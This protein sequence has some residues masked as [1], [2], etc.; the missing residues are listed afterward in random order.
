MAI[1][2][3]NTASSL[4]AILQ[5]IPGLT[6]AINGQ[7]STATTNATTSTQNNSGSTTTNSGI[8][9]DGLNALLSQLLS[10][11][12]GLA[13]VAGGQ[14][15]AG[16]YNS[17]VQQQA[18]NQL[19]VE[20]AGE[21]QA[22]GPTSTTVQNTGGTTSNTSGATTTVKAPSL[23]LGTTLLEAAG[24]IG[25]NKVLS[26]G[27]SALSNSTLGQSLANALG[28]G[29]GSSTAASSAAA[30]GAFN[31]GA[32]SAGVP[33]VGG[34]IGVSGVGVNTAGFTA[35]TAASLGSTGGLGG[36]SAGVSTGA[37]GVDASTA[38]VS[39]S[40]AGGADASGLIDAGTASSLG[41]GAGGAAAGLG[42]G[43]GAA[44]T[45]TAIAG[46][47]DAGLAAGGATL[48]GIGGAI[49]G[50]V[51]ASTAGIAAA[52]GVGDAAGAVAAGGG[53]GDALA[54]I[55]TA[56]AA[57]WVVCTELESIG[58]MQKDTYQKAAPDFVARMTLK[59][60]AVRGYHYWAVPYTR[61]M[62]RKDWVGSVARWAMRPIANGRANM[63][64]GKPNF[65]GYVTFLVI[66]PICSLLGNTVARKPQNWQSLYSKKQGEK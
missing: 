44:G 26:T 21:V 6:E 45:A 22:K 27:E 41:F 17:T 4:G 14:N 7:S 38:G 39:T 15:T 28:L 55:G 23:D 31:A 3:D 65:F 64:N 12:Q 16:L 2:A 37:A 18:V 35:P 49:G 42:A 46:A 9:A 19:A 43:L 53:I 52:E 30:T 58:E 57:A 32:A 51:A 54:S 34:G 5:A 24:G 25:A 13:S 61:L 10:G 20:T 11:T 62:R 48:G 40:L 29:G 56:I 63:I 59:P 66:E 33:S 60:S 36:A 1:A 47:T 50:D 8:S